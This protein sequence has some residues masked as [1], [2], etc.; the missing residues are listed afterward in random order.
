M[1]SCSKE[2][3]EQ[4]EGWLSS[5]QN[6]WVQDLESLIRIPSISQ[7]VNRGSKYPFGRE[8][9]RVLEEALA[10]AGRMGFQTQCHEYYCG[11]AFL[12]GKDPTC[13]YLGIF[14]HLDVVPPGEGW[15]YPPFG[16]EREGDLIVGRGSRDN[17]G[18][19]VA[20]LY[21]VKF[22]VESQIFLNHGVRFFFGCNEELGMADV[23]YYFKSH[24]PPLFSLVPDCPFPVCYGEMGVIELELRKYRASKEQRILEFSGGVAC[25]LIPE[26][27]K[28][29]IKVGQ[30]QRIQ[31]Y[32]AGNGIEI[33]HE[34][35]RLWITS[36]GRAAH[37]AYPEGSENG[38]IKLIRYLLETDFLSDEEKE[39]LFRTEALLGG[40]YGEELGIACEDP[41]T[42]RLTCVLTRMFMDQTEWKGTVNIRYPVTADGKE[43]CRNLEKIFTDH[44][45]EIAAIGDN[46]GYILDPF[47]PAID[48]LTRIACEGLGLT[49]EAYTAK[50]GTYGRKIP[51]PAV[52]YGPNCPGPHPFGPGKGTGHLPDEAVSISGLK[53]A[54]GIF[55]E[56]L[57]ALDTLLYKKEEER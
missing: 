34:E 20:A 9:A 36:H 13:K 14:V 48:L 42:G 54:A 27:A 16:A 37:S 19:A 15:T 31:E 50:G 28:A 26:S 10:I 56:A 30:G 32:P 49:L 3:I 25:N 46:P 29:G 45:F 53:Q 4:A 17:K 21:A 11:T 35:E 23:E 55:A 22:L 39:L 57:V 43:I 18:A 5:C 52:G 24:E 1:N 51:A 12:P 2:I 44:G 7:P 38:I 47:H 33:C 41:A 8:C 40:C 6:Q